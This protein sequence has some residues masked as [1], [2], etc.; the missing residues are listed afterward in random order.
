MSARRYLVVITLLATLGIG[1]GIIANGE[2]ANAFGGQRC[3]TET[4]GSLLNGPLMPGDR[5]GEVSFNIECAE[6]GEFT[7]TPQ[8]DGSAELAE[9]IEVSVTLADEILYRG[10][11][12]TLSVAQSLS[13]GVT[14]IVVVGVLKLDYAAG[15]DISVSLVANVSGI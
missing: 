1:S 9:A 11:L 13:P 8:L 10:P 12:S 3:D 14:R 5:T 15:G 2:L 7:L 4:E 6:F